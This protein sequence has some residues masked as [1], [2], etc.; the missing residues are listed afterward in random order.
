M[1]DVGAAGHFLLLC[2]TERR[3]PYAAVFERLQYDVTWVDNAPD[4]LLHCMCAPPQA[5][6]IDTAS[7]ARIGA[8]SINPLLRLQMAWPV[9]RCTPRAD[10]VVNVMC[11]E[12]DRHGPLVDVLRAIIAREPGWHVS[13]GRRYLRV[14]MPCRARLLRDGE[15]QWLPANCQ[16]ISLTGMFVITYAEYN[17]GD[18]LKVEIRDICAEP[19]PLK[20]YVSWCRRW[21][22]G[23]LLP[24]VGV[25]FHVDT[26][27]PELRLAIAQAPT[28]YPIC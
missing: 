15:D 12:R 2:A 16:D 10:G 1:S 8:A 20:G 28:R 7:S 13:W 17:A 9:L 4:L 25:G 19:M 3:A 26:M 22:D 6:L 18:P 14:A 5:V 11:T 23:V 27:P 24:G 21:E